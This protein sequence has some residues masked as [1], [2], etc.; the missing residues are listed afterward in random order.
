MALDFEHF[1]F[2]NLYYRLI[3][4]ILDGIGLRGMDSQFSTIGIKPKD[5]AQL[6]SSLLGVE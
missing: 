2:Q 5:E 3:K 1:L 4:S 6:E